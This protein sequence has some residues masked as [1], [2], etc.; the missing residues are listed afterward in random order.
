MALNTKKLY[1]YQIITN[2]LPATRC[3]GFKAKLLR[4]CGANIGENTEIFSSA[5]FQG[6]YNL[7]IGDHVFIG[8]D[9]LIFGANGSN[10]TIEDY[11][12]IGSRAVIVTGSHE[13]S[14]KYPSVAGPGYYKDIKIKRGAAIDTH[15]IILPGKTIGEK[16]HV[17]AGAIVT[18]DVPDFVRV[19]GIPAKIIKDFRKDDIESEK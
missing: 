13:Y 1:I 7:T 8:H 18:K 15:S 16:S 9:A 19:A 12:K 4:W 17:V 5:K 10:I 3:F 11:A 14:I 2:F 6:G